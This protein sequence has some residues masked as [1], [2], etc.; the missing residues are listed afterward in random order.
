MISDWSQIY[1][2]IAVHVRDSTKYLLIHICALTT[3]VSVSYKRE[4]RDTMG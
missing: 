3:F 1:D 2:I 4:T